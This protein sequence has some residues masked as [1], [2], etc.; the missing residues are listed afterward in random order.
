MKSILVN[1]VF[2]NGTKQSQLRPRFGIATHSLDRRIVR[3]N[4]ILLR[5]AFSL[6][7][8]HYFT[9]NLKIDF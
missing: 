5:F 3:Y 8:F 9:E 7:T 1:N 4:F 6:F 2:S